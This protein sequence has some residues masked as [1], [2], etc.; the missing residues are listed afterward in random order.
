[1]LTEISVV[2]LLALA[3]L[4]VGRRIPVRYN[5]RNLVVRWKT[6]LMTALAFTLV[7]GLFVVM[8]G[9]VNG[10]YRL[11]LGSGQPGNVIILSERATDEVVSNISPT[12]IGDL[13]TQPGILREN[14]RPV[15]SR[16]TY[17]VIN[18]PMPHFT[19]GRP[20]RRFLQVR[21][22][23]DPVL[24]G[25]VHN[26]SLFEDGG[27]FSEAG[28]RQITAGGKSARDDQPVI[29]AV[30]GEGVA[31]ELG[32]DRTAEQLA[33]SASKQR[34]DTGDCFELAGRQWLV[35]GVLQSAGSTFNSEIWAK[36][37]LV[38]S[39]LGKDTY[40]S[41]VVR[42]ADEQAA[43]ELAKY[44]ATR[45]KRV[46]VQAEVE[47]EYYE[48]LSNTNKQFLYAIVF[49][50]VVM[51]LGG[52]FGVMNTMYAA[53]SQRT[54]DIGILRLLGYS[55]WQLLRSFLL[56]SLLIAALG[57]VLGCG[58]GLLSD[59]LSATSLVSSGP[60]GGKSVVLRLAIDL[61]IL[62]AGML[63]A[64]TMGVLGGVLPSLAAMR[65]R[66]LEALR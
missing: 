15:A 32:R 60:A 40:T 33:A 56:E 53:I 42:T 2:A 10:M 9:F 43:R 25:R 47:T 35:V 24:A 14:G 54:A 37:S 21:G 19:D 5:A 46:P 36:R 1:M 55:R 57:G 39:L 7:I 4:L 65:T 27:W 8:L 34:L 18:Q 41:L 51:S 66:P 62:S 38:A 50:T 49:V 29:E 58:I 44:F 30:L 6:T 11:T 3:V 59:G 17:L 45:Y 12:D 20:S 63:L 22:L 31:R 13:E 16:E 64:L 48:S 26:L 23:D 28:A 52:T 61:R